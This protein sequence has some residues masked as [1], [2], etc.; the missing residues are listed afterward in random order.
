MHKD[1]VA[2]NNLSIIALMGMEIYNNPLKKL[3]NIEHVN[4]EIAMAF[5]KS[6]FSRTFVL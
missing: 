1:N 6:W 4:H 5:L 2:A 3:I